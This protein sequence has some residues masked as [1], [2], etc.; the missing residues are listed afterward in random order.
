M[1]TQKTLRGGS[2]NLEFGRDPE[3]V[4]MEVI[5]FTKKHKLD[6]LC[7]QEAA[8][9]TNQLK[10]VP[11]YVFVAGGSSHAARQSPILVKDTLSVSK[12]ESVPYGN[13][14]R[15]HGGLV[16]AATVDTVCK[17]NWL[18]VRSIHLPTPSEWVNGHIGGRTPEGRKDDLI[19]GMK[20]LQGFLRF[21]CI[22]VARIIV[23]DWNEPP[24]TSG[25]YSPRWLANV[26]KAKSY[27]PVSRE[28]HGHI[29]W[30]MVKGAHITNIAKDLD[31]KEG[32]DHEPVFF[33][34]VKNPKVKIR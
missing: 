10:T 15:G 21:P 27:T 13:G 4:R 5:N 29:D 9:Y 12:V 19:A 7:L 20:S 28:G 18:K 3:T 24:T 14:W 11:G 32:S 17:I 6:F 25:E 2:F 1:K 30:A 16:H 22:F 31:I 26:S 23:G 33:T 8:D 34:V